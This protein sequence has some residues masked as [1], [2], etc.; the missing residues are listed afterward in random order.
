MAG[1]PAGA[2]LIVSPPKSIP[3][4]FISNQHPTAQSIQKDLT[5]TIDI[6]RSRSHIRSWSRIYIL[7][8]TIRTQPLPQPLTV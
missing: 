3:K 6:V 1:A 5:F 8:R 7:I 4:E 2:S